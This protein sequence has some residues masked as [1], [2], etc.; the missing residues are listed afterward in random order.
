MSKRLRWVAGA[1]ALL[2]ALPLAALAIAVLVI[3]PNDYK[4]EIAAAVEQATG[5][6]LILNGPLRVSRS[7]WPTIAVEDVRLANLPGGS[8]P[9]IA[10]AERIE[11]QLSLPSLLWRQIEFI[12]LTLIGPNILFEQVDGKPN[13]VFKAPGFPAD[14]TTAGA[15]SRI[16]MRF[17]AVH[18]QNGMVTTRLPARTNVVGIRSLD[19]RRPREAG[20][21]EISSV[22]VYSDYQPFRLNAT[23][24]PTGG[25]TDPWKTRLDFAAY[26]TR[27][28]ATGTMD[29]GGDYDLRVTARSQELEKLNAL[30]P[31]V[32]LPA[33]R[34]I[35]VSTHLSNGPVRGALPVVGETSILFASA[36]LS[37]RAAGLQLG[38]VDVNLPAAGGLATVSGTGSISGQRFDVSGTAG[39]P[40]H[41][42]GAND[43]PLNI[44]AEAMPGAKN[45]RTD[46]DGE[47]SL[48]LKGRLSLNTLRF[49]GLDAAV[50]L[51]TPALA[52]LRP[53]VSQSLPALTSVALDGNV[54]IPATAKVLTLKDAKLTS[55]QG[56]L[57]GDVRI[58]LG[59]AV[60]FKGKFRSSTLDADSLLAALGLS[61]AHADTPASAAS[62]RIIPDQTM[63]WSLLRGPTVDVSAD[64]GAMILHHRTWRDVRLALTLESGRLRI[65]RLRIPLP[66]GTMSTSLTIDASADPVPITLVVDAPA[67]PLAV[68]AQLAGLPGEATGSARINAT[69]RA[70]GASTF[71][72]VSSLDGPFAATMVGGT[73]SNAALIELASSSLAAL[74]I[75]VPKQGTTT[76]HCIRVSGQFSKGSGKISTVAV[77]TAYLKL[78]GEGTVDLGTEKME[79]RL[80]PLAQ[81]SGS[82]VKVPVVVEGPLNSA[83]GRLD[84][85]GLDKLGYL[86]NAWLGG[87]QSKICADA[88]LLPQLGR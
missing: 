1:A 44:R 78:A 22:L 36:D 64:I 70:A 63:P 41:P 61:Q 55:Q 45:R 30:Q 74:G 5:R 24:Q 11:A 51:R 37:D 28:E 47:G 15:P 14:P 35:N 39:I 69:L 9:D 48:A 52:W 65:D 50:T 60:S 66:G 49:A 8:R 67:V 46:H 26:D 71:A 31:Y 10:R 27:A 20:P 13:W 16:S 57:A 72:I 34:G 56:D 59:S 40:E 43:V 25:I 7:L 77:D 79:F 23:A 54:T 84:A 38:A 12:S 85:S 87:D 62:G 29:L 17:R 33:L 76:I 53:T 18:V 75:T 81:L 73:I 3:D 83:V 32:R 80:Y 6:A 21:L 68:I 19:L 58:G 2:F 82:L 86:I 88:G 4:P 42:D